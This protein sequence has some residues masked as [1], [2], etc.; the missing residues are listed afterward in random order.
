VTI[1]S[2]QLYSNYGQINS[3]L[4]AQTQDIKTNTFYGGAGPGEYIEYFL[5][6]NVTANGYSISSTALNWNVAVSTNYTAWTIIDTKSGS[7][8]SYNLYGATGN[9]FRVTSNQT[10]G[11][12]SFKMNSFKLFTSNGSSI[13]P[14]L[15]TNV[16]TSIAAQYY[17][18]LVDDSLVTVTQSNGVYP[19]GR[20]GNFT[21]AYAWG[22]SPEWIQE[23]FAISNVVP[24]R[25]TM[26][27]FPKWQL[28]ASNSSSNNWILIA[29]QASQSTL[30]VAPYS[31]FRLN[32]PIDAPTYTTGSLVM[33]DQGSNVI[34]NGSG[35]YGGS[36][37]ARTPFTT[38]GIAGDWVQFQ[39][40]SQVAANAVS[41]QPNLSYNVYGSN[42]LTNF[43]LLGNA[44]TTY[45][46]YR[47]VFTS[48]IGG[49]SVVI[50]EISPLNS[51][52]LALVPA[53]VNSN[54]TTNNPQVNFRA[55]QSPSLNFGPTPY[56]Y[57]TSGY[58]GSTST[59][60]LDLA[61][62]SSKTIVGDYSTV[63]FNFPC[64]ITKYIVTLPTS[65]STANA[66]ALVGSNDG[67]NSG[68]VISYYVNPSAVNGSQI[69]VATVNTYTYSQLRFIYVGGISSLSTFSLQVT[70]PVFV[71]P[72]GAYG[73]NGSVYSN[74]STTTITNPAAATI[75]GDWV[76]ITLP[77]AATANI[78]TFTT[79][80]NPISWYLVGAQ[81][82]SGPWDTLHSVSNNYNF[83]ASSI[84]TIKN[85]SNS[86][87]VYRLIITESSL[88]SATAITIALYNVYGN[89]LIPI[90]TS[91]VTTYSYKP[92]VST[93]LV[94][95]FN[96]STSISNVASLFDYNPNTSWYTSY[97]STA[98]T[99]YLSTQITGDWFDVTLPQPAIL[100]KYSIL[101]SPDTGNSPNSWIV[102]G[103]TDGTNFTNV[104]S[105]VQGYFTSFPTPNVY[106]TFPVSNSTPF[107]RLRFIVQQSI[108]N[109]IDLRQFRIF[110][111]T[112]SLL[113]NVS[114]VAGQTISVDSSS[115]QG[116]TPIFGGTVYT[117][118]GSPV[119]SAATSGASGVLQANFI[120]DYTQLTFPVPLLSM[121]NPPKYIN[122][123][124]QTLPSNV[125]ILGAN[126]QTGNTFSQPL[127]GTGVA[128]G[129]QVVVGNASNVYNYG[130]VMIPLT[131]LTV[132]SA[133]GN[134]NVDIVRVV[135]SESSGTTAVINEIEF[136]DSLFRRIN[137]YMTTPTNTRV[138]PASQAVIG[139]VNVITNPTIP[140]G[141]YRGSNSTV[142]SGTTIS[143]D[144]IQLQLGVLAGIGLGTPW[145]YR[146]SFANTVSYWTL[147]GYDGSAWQLIENRRPK[148]TGNVFQYS[149]GFQ[150][151][152]SAFRLIGRETASI[153]CFQVAELSILNQNWD[154]LNPY[155]TVNN[156]SVPNANIATNG[157]SNVAS[158]LGSD[159]FNGDYIILQTPSSNNGV[160]SMSISTS[161]NLQQFSVYGS[162]DGLAWSL[163]VRNSLN[164]LFGTYSSNASQTF[165][166][167]VLAVDVNTSGVYNGSNPV[168]TV[169]TAYGS[170]SGGWSEVVFP[171]AV[172]ANTMSF[173]VPSNSLFGNIVSYYVLGSNDYVTWTRLYEPDGSKQPIG[174]QLNLNFNNTLQFVYYRVMI[175]QLDR[176]AY[177]GLTN[178]SFGLSGG[179]KTQLVGIE[180]TYLTDLVSNTV[181]ISPYKYYG[182]QFERMD[183][184]TSFTVSSISMSTNK[185][186]TGLFPPLPMTSNTSTIL[187]YGNN[188]V[189]TG[190]DY[191]QI[192]T[193]GPAH[194][195]N[196]YTYGFN[197][198]SNIGIP[199]S[200]T[201]Y[202]SNDGLSFEFIDSNAMNYT[203]RTMASNVV[204]A[205]PTFTGR[206]YNTFRLVVNSSL[207]TFTSGGT[208]GL[209]DFYVNDYYSSVSTPNSA[210][211]FTQNTATSGPIIVQ[212]NVYNQNG[213][214]TYV[215]G[216]G[217]YATFT[218]PKS[219][220]LANISIT[221]STAFY[222]NLY[223][224]RTLLI[225]IAVGTG[226]SNFPV[227]TGNYYSTYTLVVSNVIGQASIQDVS[228]YDILG[229][230]RP[231]LIPF[232]LQTN[233]V[234]DTGYLNFS[235]LND[236]GITNTLPTT[237]LYAVSRNLLDIK[238]GRG[239]TRFIN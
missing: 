175:T 89:H 158:S 51:S 205:Y 40:S 148:G 177:M 64:A 217:E 30:N 20:L 12:S 25:V 146:V 108:L 120:G 26:S 99:P 72:L 141:T 14:T 44:Q 91:G 59:V 54:Q 110:N 191:V 151:G 227:S 187:Y 142:V 143:G 194:T 156:P 233:S 88:N 10:V 112:G 8:G 186:Q 200:V 169:N 80:C 209:T 69:N 104:M 4:T 180:S 218:F 134:L 43:V 153:N 193:S 75:V 215:N 58:I 62:G 49:P 154:Q 234:A 74:T 68:N 185:V 55:L 66:W 223:G 213:Q 214:Y 105:N 1:N 85:I 45:N 239:R 39:Y 34:S 94:G 41:I 6:A 19:S 202:G 197:Q 23:S 117:S 102:L 31:S 220:L 37:V 230:R 7:S 119:Y 224:D 178:L 122:I 118:T 96:M 131:N 114:F 86:Y 57:K 212:A 81:T 176:R 201:L 136:L 225:P 168:F 140:Y 207:Q 198:Y 130:N 170:L 38:A 17:G 123:K 128:T 18:Y 15:T 203:D 78:Y 138:D 145:G 5:P 150:T 196:S 79:D 107:I 163:I 135:I 3:I 125:W 155:L 173:T 65:S 206:K 87:A 228:F 226:T 111:Q 182:V 161:A 73:S 28:L 162:N 13:I 95:Q 32:I 204:T 149:F 165:L 63:T 106:S 179:Q 33:Y 147:C 184:N 92:P 60:F 11:S 115:F 133:I 47:V 67:F 174:T 97:I 159:R 98:T 61:T 144:W 24:T 77:G 183:T 9:I 236:F 42:N 16:S 195:A 129:G 190:S 2:L 70:N 113:P 181:A 167:G 127:L 172:I 192:T 84:N 157:W 238:D 27:G 100:T 132:S 76:Q 219:I 137:P 126:A 164:A 109:G 82:T 210:V 21:Y 139:G 56:N 216:Q 124:S 83:T 229:E 93:S 189:G 36:Y 46:T 171:A 101:H 116:C 235:Q 22:T 199:T 48:S 237:S 52:G 231:F 188:S 90:L 71:G 208:T 29:T 121:S 35:T 152:Y 103:S 232:C 160:N 53:V 222:G 211:V 50:P 166:P 221:T